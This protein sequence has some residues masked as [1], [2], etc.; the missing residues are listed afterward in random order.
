MKTGCILLAA[1][2]GIRFGGDKLK[3]PLAG[4]P[5]AEHILSNLPRSSFD[6]CL[7]VAAD[8]ELLELADRFGVPGVIN[9]RPDL[10]VARSIRMGLAALPET[11]ACMFCVCDQPLLQADTIAGMVR[12]YEAGSILCLS[13]HGKHGN[14]VIFP[15]SL[16]GELGALPAGGSGKTI[17][18]AHPDLVRTYDI[19]DKAQ[20]LDADTR[21]QLERIETLLLTR[22]Q[23]L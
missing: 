23:H 2:A 18:A 10:G 7:M 9:N 20:L 6:H 13:S 3:A 5:M 15:A 14:P 8:N 19:P 17:T 21:E 22:S 1:G 11:D 12:S 4:I 16:F